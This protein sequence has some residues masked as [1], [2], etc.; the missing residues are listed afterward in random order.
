MA[1]LVALIIPSDLAHAARNRKSNPEPESKKYGAIVVD[2]STG[3]V[4][5]SDH[6]DKQLHPASLTKM[7]TLLL[8]FDA[9]SSGQLRTSDY[10]RVSKHAAAQSPSKLGIRSGGR[11]RVD[12]AIRAIAIKSANDISVAMAEALGE[13]ESR[14]AQRMTARAREI[15]MSKTHFVNASGLHSAF[16][17]STPRDMAVLARYIITTYP[18]YYKYFG[19]RSFNYAGRSHPNH[20]R[21]MSSY[22]GMDG[23]KTGF[24]NASGFNLVA[25]AKRDGR[26]LIGVV[27]GGR[28]AASRNAHMAKILDTAFATPSIRPQPKIDVARI[29]RM[30]DRRS[31]RETDR[32]EDFAADDGAFDTTNPRD[33]ARVRPES[34]S[35]ETGSGDIDMPRDTLIIREKP[36]TRHQAAVLPDRKPVKNNVDTRQLALNTTGALRTSPIVAGTKS[37]RGWAVQLGAYQTRDATDAALHQASR[38]LPN[39]LSHAVPSV[40]PLKSTR[41]GWMFRARLGNLTKAEAGQTCQIFSGCVLIPPQQN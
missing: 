37:S 8:A 21:L 22:Y 34:G 36:I 30:P 12:D 9:L 39:S 35:D 32:G 16:Q 25:S 3:Q 1:V 13:T 6:A 28:T 41:D 4:L 31:S 10:I 15:G 40:A 17:L 18:S 38:R 14:F 33:L 5:M 26:R 7:M 20:N 24:I 2:A 11:I 19:L 29:S 23:M 27:F